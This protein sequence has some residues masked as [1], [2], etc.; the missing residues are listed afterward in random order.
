M[1]DNMSRNRRKILDSARRIF[2]EK[3]YEQATIKEICADAGVA[4]STFYYHFKTKEE[5]M[6][7]LRE[8]DDRPQ[9]QDILNVV[10]AG[11]LLEQMITACSMCAV[12]AQR[13]GWTLTAQYYKRKLSAEGTTQEQDASAEQELL[14]AQTMVSRAQSER[15]IANL[16][17]PQK[18]A[19]SAIMLTN[20]VI[21]SW[22]MAEGGFDLQKRV[23]DELQTLLGFDE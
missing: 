14:V 13:H 5:L 22:C 11:S 4:N 21:I 3:S 2:S 12:R 15:L 9:Q 8:K 18:L 20:S 1:N 16:R 7:C 17:D 6:D 23:R 19:E 10:T